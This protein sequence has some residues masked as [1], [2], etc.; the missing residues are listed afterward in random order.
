M[1]II[2]ITGTLCSGKKTA[3]EYLQMCFGFKILDVESEKWDQCGSHSSNVYAEDDYLN[4]ESY[5]EANARLILRSTE[6]NIAVNY[7]IYPITLPEELSVFRTASNFMLIGIDAPTL[8]RFGHYNVKYIRR[9]SPLANFLEIDD[10]INFG[11]NGYPAHVYECMYSSDKIVVNSG[12]KDRFFDDLRA[13]EVLNPEHYRPGWDTY[14]MRIAEMAATRTNCMKRG[15]G[16]VVV[17]NYRVISAGYNGTPAGILNCIDGGCPRCSS[18]AEQGTMLEDCMCMHG[19]LNAILFAGYE[20][21]AGTTLYT[22]LFPCL[23]CAKSIVQAG[24]V[25]VVYE[26]EYNHSELSFSLLEQAGI[27]IDRHSSIVPSQF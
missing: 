27:K 25:R 13:L 18:Q 15:V 20:N 10:K 3:A 4:E 23:L 12:E 9:K 16:A 24:I 5:R 1:I 19:E 11:L 6:E 8:K 17:N 2:G 21:C 22:T 26:E 7:V 14:F